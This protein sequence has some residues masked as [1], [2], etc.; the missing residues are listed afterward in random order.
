[1]PS[2]TPLP[3]S[4]VVVGF[5][6]LSGF[7]V[8]G[9]DPADPAPNTTIAGRAAVFSADKPGSCGGDETITVRIPDPGGNDIM[10]RACLS[11]PDLTVGEQT[12]QAIL[13]SATFTGP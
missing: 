2:F 10:V 1:L 3:V 7:G 6:V 5:G 12:I 4:A 13:T 11:G 9:P 8:G